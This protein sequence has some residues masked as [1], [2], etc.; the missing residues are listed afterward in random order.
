MTLLPRTSSS[1]VSMTVTQASYD[2]PAYGF[3]VAVIQNGAALA[4]YAT[5]ASSKLSVST[6]TIGFDFS[7]IEGGDAEIIFSTDAP[8]PTTF[9]LTAAQ[10]FG[11]G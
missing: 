9:D 3:S 4:H 2:H 10:I 7:T 6:L 8:E 1:V 11:E 5:E